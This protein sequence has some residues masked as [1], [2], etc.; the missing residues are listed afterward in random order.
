MDS[1]HSSQ[2]LL[3]QNPTSTTNKHQNKKT[4]QKKHRNKQSKRNNT[5]FPTALSTKPS[6]TPNYQHLPYSWPTWLLT[7]SSKLYRLPYSQSIL[8]NCT[9]AIVWWLWL[10]LCLGSFCIRRLPR[11]SIKLWRMGKG[12]SSTVPLRRNVN[13]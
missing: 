9:W 1:K 8:L 3:P 4:T 12:L 13:T 11:I 2:P 6:I 10:I 7:S 5:S